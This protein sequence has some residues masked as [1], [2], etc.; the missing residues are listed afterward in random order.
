MRKFA[1]FLSLVMLSLP[2]V[3][4]TQSGTFT[5]TVPN[6]A[7]PLN[8]TT[9]TKPD[10]VQGNP[11]IK[12]TKVEQQL[13]GGGWADITNA[14]TICDNNTTSPDVKYGEDVRG[15]T[16]RYTYEMSASSPTGADPKAD[17]SNNPSNQCPEEPV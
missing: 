6:P 14:V 9:I 16:F 3:A 10:D 15:E 8:Q 7:S 13:V 5:S 12:I 2:I 11:N 17:H 1:A 4:Q